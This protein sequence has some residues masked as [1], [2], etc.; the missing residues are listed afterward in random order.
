M[1]KIL[2]VDDDP[3]IRTYLSTFLGDKGYTTLVAEDGVEGMNAVHKEKP[4][5]ITLDIIMPNQTGVKMYRIIKNDE[6]LKDIPV[7]IVS[8]V[9]QYKDLFRKSHRTM[10][11]PVAFIEKPVN[12][13]VLLEKIKE[14][15]G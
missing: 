13:D 10:P 11:K 9:T 8:G 1:A 2:I 7:I 5:L 6:G 14:V 15:I 3:D 4:D 12:R